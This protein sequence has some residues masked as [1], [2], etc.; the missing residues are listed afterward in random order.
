MSSR[1][2]DRKQFISLVA[3][4]AAIGTFLQACGDDSTPPTGTG[5]TGNTSGSGGSGAGGTGMAG[6]TGMGGTGAGGTGAGGTGSGGTGAGG[7]GAGGTGAGGTGAG[8]TGAGGTGA[9]GTGAGGRGGTGAGG[10]SGGGGGGMCGTASIMHTS[11]NPHTHIP[12]DATMLKMNLKMLINGNMSTMMFTLPK[13][14]LGQGHV[15]TIT[16]TAAQ[17]TTLKGGGMVTGIKSSMDEAH[18]HT[19]TISCG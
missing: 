12:S 15:H 14:G 1:T 3:A 16:L 10:G 5:G 11:D 8:G 9:G 6:A 17:V 13:D 2:L 4:S 7:T 19:Y 18:D